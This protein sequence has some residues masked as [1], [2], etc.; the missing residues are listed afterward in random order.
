MQVLAYRLNRS[1]GKSD[2]V[3]EEYLQAEVGNWFFG[4]HTDVACRFLMFDIQSDIKAF[5]LDSLLSQKHV[6]AGAPLE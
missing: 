5:P 6:Q 1:D 4:S 2:M 3:R